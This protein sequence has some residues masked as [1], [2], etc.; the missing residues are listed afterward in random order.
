MG[1][2]RKISVAA[3]AGLHQGRRSSK[4]HRRASVQQGRH[5]KKEMVARPDHS[6]LL[7]LYEGSELVIFREKFC[8]WPD[9]SR[10]IRMKGGPVGDLGKVIT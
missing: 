8:D 7:L 9:E 10:M 4:Q 5:Q 2:S 6:L 3:G 1:K